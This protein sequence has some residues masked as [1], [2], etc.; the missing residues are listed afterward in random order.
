MTLGVRTG[1][2]G[3]LV[4]DGGSNLKYPRPHAQSYLAE[5]VYKDVFQK[6]F[7]AQIRQFILYYY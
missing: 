1:I 6:A 5:S 2:S 7:H 4:V 3:A